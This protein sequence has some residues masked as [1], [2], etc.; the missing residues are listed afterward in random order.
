M[1]INNMQKLVQSFKSH[2]SMRGLIGSGVGTLFVFLILTPAIHAGQFAYE[3]WADVDNWFDWAGTETEFQE[4]PVGTTFIRVWSYTTIERP[5]DITFT[6]ILF[7]DLHDGRNFTQFSSQIDKGIKVDI[8]KPGAEPVPEGHKY[9]GAQFRYPW[10][11]V[12]AIP[13]LPATCYIETKG[14]IDLNF[15]VQKDDTWRTPNFYIK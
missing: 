1:K 11:Y 9:S 13:Q 14:Q 2:V 3:Y 5:V 12:N 15:D 8:D 6:D 10:T 4:Y 7:C